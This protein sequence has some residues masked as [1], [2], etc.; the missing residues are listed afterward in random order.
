MRLSDMKISHK[1][2]AL[3][4]VLAIVIAVVAGTG[5]LGLKNVVEGAQAITASSRLALVAARLN[6]NTLAMNRAEFRIAADPNRESID[7]AKKVIE[8]QQKEFE[9]RFDRIK[10]GLAAD[11][12][13]DQDTQ[14]I[15]SISQSYQ[16]YAAELEGTFRDVAR[17]AS[18][19]ETSQAQKDIVKS[20]MGSRAKA[21]ALIDR[22]KAGADLLSQTSDSLTDQ[23]LSDGARTEIVMIAVGLIGI[24][25]GVLIGYLLARFS[26]SKPLS[27]SLGCLRQLSTGDVSTR[28][29]GSG[30]KDEIG[31]IAAAMETF[32]E[33]L[34]K[35][36]QMQEREAQAQAERLRRAQLIAELTDNFDTEASAIVK[37]VAAASTEM[38]STATALSSNAEETSRQST[39]VAGAAEQTS[40]NVQTVA[41][42][43]EE[44]ASSVNEIGRQ[45]S[46]STKISSEAVN[47]AELA[48]RT[49]NSLSEAATRIGSVIQIITDI[50]SQTNLLALNATIE[51]AR[52]GEAGK[53]FAVVASE[54][55]NLANQTSQ[56]TDEI[57]KQIGEM[58][59]A[60]VG[61]V[62]SIGEIR[63][64]IE[65][66]N[67]IASGIAAA[68][69]EQGT[70]TQEISRN[71]QQAAQGTQD[72]TS[73][74]VSVNDAAQETGTA[75]TQLLAGASELSEQ[76][77]GLRQ[78]V[79]TF[80]AGVRAA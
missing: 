2:M 53:G 48:N 71:V 59:S 57:S 41:S 29:F 80:L 61:A 13:S 5:I 26:I 16:D 9:S 15:D 62:D 47:K 23:A 33:N 14:F 46:E 64:I 6:Q 1:L 68:V 19:V 55:K 40:A 11:G 21:E 4:A 34:I 36:N 30:R 56:A 54:V 52:A 66:L 49:I 42:A 32:K 63:I 22:V 60:T 44:L 67:T 12:L 10:T 24:L 45:V 37:S 69:E 72:V 39:A 35:N 20:V 73:N 79:E 18:Q 75:A 38:Q 65:N 70:A 51:A 31:D 28:I 25:G 58:Q 17:L 8:G 3:V 27:A 78:K 74:I 77:E 50:A 76:A 7:A 43:A